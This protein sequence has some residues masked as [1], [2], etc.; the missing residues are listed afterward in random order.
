M[1]CERSPIG[2]TRTSNLPATQASTFGSASRPPKTTSKRLIFPIRRETKRSCRTLTLW[3]VDGTQPPPENSISGIGESRKSIHEHRSHLRLQT[4]LAGF[5]P[6]IRRYI[7]R[8]FSC[9]E[10]VLQ[11]SHG[12]DRTNAR[13]WSRFFCFNPDSGIS[14]HRHHEYGRDDRRFTDILGGLCSRRTCSIGFL[15]RRS[16]PL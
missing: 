4:F 6:I 16:T 7:S 11:H 12:D 1:V 3:S 5:V 13:R 14:A 8:R 9:H 10:S 2:S 15:A